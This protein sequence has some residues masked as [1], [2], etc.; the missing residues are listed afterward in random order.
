MHLHITSLQVK[1]KM[2]IKGHPWHYFEKGVTVYRLT[3][4]NSFSFFLAIIFL[5]QVII[6]L[7]DFFKYF[8]VDIT[9]L[10]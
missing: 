9:E 8:V 3:Y 2:S 6:M 7:P 1:K 4:I 10:F 5:N